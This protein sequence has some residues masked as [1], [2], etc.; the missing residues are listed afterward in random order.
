ML[1]YYLTLNG[2]PVDKY[3]HC[4]LLT[5]LPKSKNFECAVYS[6]LLHLNQVKSVNGVKM[7]CLIHE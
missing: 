6:N 3:N 1:I 5:K 7:E 4:I 2:K